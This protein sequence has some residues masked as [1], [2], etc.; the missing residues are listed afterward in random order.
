MFRLLN[1]AIF[2]LYMNPYKGDI[3]DLIWAVYEWDEVDTRSDM[4]HGGRGGVHRVT[5]IVYILV[6]NS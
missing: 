4:C 3:Q 1:I 6:N 5:A 2:R